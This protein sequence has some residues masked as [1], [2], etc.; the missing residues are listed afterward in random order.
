MRYLIVVFLIAFIAIN[1]DAQ[2][3]VDAQI[4]KVSY[5]SSQNVYVK[6]ESTKNISVGDTLFSTR[7]NALVPVLVVTALSSTSC[8]CTSISDTALPISMEIATKNRV[9]RTLPKNEI[10]KPKAANDSIVT[11]DTEK[12]VK[13]SE[14]KQKINGSIS[15][16]SYSNFSNTDVANSNRYQYNL[17]LDAKNINDS[18]LSFETYTSFRYNQN[19][20]YLVKQ[21][22]FHALR[23]YS[24]NFRYDINKNNQLCFGRRVNPKISNIGAID[25]LQFETKIN[26]FSLGGFVGSRPNY[27]DYNFD[28]NLPQFGAYIAHNVKNSNGEMQNTFA[29]VNQMNSSKTDRRFAYFQHNNSLLK[30][31]YLFGSIELDLYKNVNGKAQNTLSLTS[32]YVS[33]SYRPWRRISLSTSYDIRKNVIY[34]ETYKSFINQIIDNETRQGLSFQANYNSLKNIYFGVRTGYRFPSKNSNESKN[35]YGYVTYSKVPWINVSTTIATTWL[36][37]NYLR[38]NIYYLNISRDI[39]KGKVYVESGYQYVDYSFTGAL[40][41]LRQNIVDISVSL[42]LIKNLTFSIKFEETFENSNRYSRL[43]LQLRQRF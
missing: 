4:G 8:V 11:T 28:F 40:S 20:W 25:G 22:V 42:R 7:D 31:L 43:N 9:K 2:T 41:S 33:L 29:F 5:V 10:V 35:I 37:S 13:Q 39:F 21:D 18:R 17:S 15:A 38:G 24:V 16:S 32:S 36:Q 23:F 19:E 3:K 14:Y 34:Y 27:I 1:I 12:N 26:K 30:N 6:F